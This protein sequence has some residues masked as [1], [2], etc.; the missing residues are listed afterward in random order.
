MALRDD[1]HIGQNESMETGSIGKTASIDTFDV[2]KELVKAVENTDIERY[3]EYAAIYKKHKAL[4][5]DEL[6][7]NPTKEKRKKLIEKKKALESIWDKIFEAIPESK[8]PNAVP[9]M[10]DKINKKIKNTLLDLNEAPEI[11]QEEKDQFV[12]LLEKVE[13][14]QR[15]TY[16][17]RLRSALGHRNEVKRLTGFRG[18]L[19]ELTRRDVL[20]RQGKETMGRH[21]GPIYVDYHGYGKNDPLDRPPQTHFPIDLR[22]K[23]GD[24]DFDINCIM[25]DGKPYMYEVKY[26][27]RMEY[28]TNYDKDDARKARNQLLKYEKAVKDG[29]LAGGTIELSGRI[30]PEF[31]VWMVGKDEHDEGPIPNIEVLYSM[32]LPSGREYRFPIKRSRT[33]GLKYED[34]RSNYT[35]DDK[36]VIR[37]LAQSYR[38]RTLGAVLS[39]RIIKGVDPKKIDKLEDYNKY[40]KDHQEAIWEHLTDKAID[41]KRTSVV[42]AYAENVDEEMVRNLLTD[43]QH[44]LKTNPS[45]SKLRAK[46]IIDQSRFEEV[47][48]EAMRRIRDISAFEKARLS[49]SEE[50]RRIVVRNIK[51]YGIPEEG[52]AMD[53][54][55][56]I[57]DSLQDSNAK[58]TERRGVSYGKIENFENFQNIATLLEDQDRTSKSIT[59]VD[60]LAKKSKRMQTKRAFG[61][62]KG[63][64]LRSHVIDIETK[65]SITHTNIRRAKAK[66]EELLEKREA[67]IGENKTSEQRTEY[68]R[69]QSALSGYT[70]KR[71]ARLMELEEEIGKIHA[72][73]DPLEVRNRIGKMIRDIR[74]S[75]YKEG[76]IEDLERKNEREKAL[77]EKYAELHR[78]Y[79]DIF[80]RKWKDFAMRIVENITTNIIKFAYVITAEGKVVIDEEANLSEI[81]LRASHSELAQG[82][83][84]YGAGMIVFKKEKGKWKLTEIN[85]ASGHYRPAPDTLTYVKNIISEQLPVDISGEDATI[86]DCIYRGVDIDGLPIDYR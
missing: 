35:V 82:R 49:S 20:V 86:K 39:G 47:V 45:M 22:N 69:V 70:K 9:R 17:I 71:K 81:L 61:I 68:K 15:S 63:S 84:V 27:Q 78:L 73:R 51:G 80:G 55:R 26:P 33:S 43:I 23:E 32:K 72:E 18:V 53:V 7:N 58:G 74:R 6:K 13:E 52:Y 46:Y 64:A 4:I 59:F 12:E 67:L 56:I 54:E 76:S 30:N 75:E 62:G 41:P 85:N 10:Q 28:G 8:K 19:F 77:D 3:D 21:E 36:M 16:L 50:K 11:P 31:W 44:T 2:P 79:R 66:L 5:V 34:E 48:A 14:D 1:Q 42:P 57:Y 65:Q 83:N 38:D 60:P 40:I 29:K 24:I 37:G 25:R